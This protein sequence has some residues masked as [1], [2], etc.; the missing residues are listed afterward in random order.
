MS[1][2]VN[3]RV[4]EILS[5]MTLAEK[6]DML[7]G[8][9][10]WFLKGVERLGVPS[11]RVTDCGHGVTATDQE[12]TCATCFPTAVGQA[13]TWNT[14]LLE[15]MGV[16]IGREVRA[17]GNSLLLGPMV[18]MHRMPLNGR[19]YECYSED[20]YLTGKMAAALV[21][22]IQSQDIGACI[23]G[24]T[25]NNQQANQQELDV[26]MDERTL[27]EIYLPNFRI[28]VEEAKPWAI[29]TCYNGLNGHHSSSNRHL[30]TEI[31]KEAW[32][33]DGFIVSDW[34]GTHNPD[35]VTSGLDLEMPGPGKF[36]RQADIMAA[37][38]D[39]RLTEADLDDHVKRLLRAVVKTG[40]VDGD[41]QGQIAELDSPTHRAM[42]RE[43]AGESIT[44]L[45]NQNDLLPL[46]AT[47][48]STIAVIGPNAEQARLGG[49]GSASVS[50]FYSVGP[51]A[52]IRSRCGDAIHVA[53]DEGCCFLGASTVIY[54]DFLT[55]PDGQMGLAAEFFGDQ[56]LGGEP[57][58][59]TTHEQIDFSW[60][61]AAPGDGAQRNHWSARWT[62][63][64]TPPATGRYKLGAACRDGGLRLCINGRVVLDHWG[65]PGGEHSDIS[66]NEVYCDHAEIDLVEGDPVEIRLEYY[67]TANKSALRL[68]WTVPG[69]ADPVERAATV[70]GEADIAVVCAGLSNTYEGGTNDRTD[71]E[72]PGRQVELIRAVAAA[73]PNT[74][75]VLVNGTP[76]NVQPWIDDVPAVLEAG[77]R[78]T[79][80]GATTPAMKRPSDTPKASSSATATTTP[81][82]SSRPSRSASACRTRSSSTATR[83]CPPTR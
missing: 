78:T 28:P 20:P 75:V 8:V 2:G 69:W 5:E 51:L 77:W 41:T 80:R 23:K 14:D 44:L 30:L 82:T 40:L 71:I 10:M 53:Y 73:N 12:R 36:M 43:I 64:L 45:R 11:I 81:G 15:R 9:D 74:V 32:G 22:G 37:L 72:L 63:T 25:A 67:K 33:F 52:G 83:R 48:M 56:Q 27:R 39:G 4:E 35:V 61:W 21:R 55:T 7:C 26:Q 50:P 1:S 13:A 6:A 17:L 60:G 62:G 54:R 16:V 65:S 79:P 29:M 59:T 68:E 19:S 47:T 38:D 34:R 57:T 76:L 49:G 24:C 70:A 66:P 3:R 58:Y 46:D 31:V 42:A 18:N